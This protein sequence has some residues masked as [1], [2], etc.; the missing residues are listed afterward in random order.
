MDEWR[1]GHKSILAFMDRQF[2][3]T[4]WRTVLNWRKKGMPFHKLQN[5]KPCLIE[6]EVIDW[7]IKNFSR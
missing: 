4:S 1:V 5:G 7:Q 2:G 3:V 6:K